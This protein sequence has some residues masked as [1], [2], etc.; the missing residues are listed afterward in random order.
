M[1]SC[2]DPTGIDFKKVNLESEDGKAFVADLTN[3]ANSD[4]NFFTSISSMESYIKFADSNKEKFEL[5]F[6]I[7]GK[8][9]GSDLTVNLKNIF[10]LTSKDGMTE[11][12]I[13][14]SINDKNHVINFNLAN[15]VDGKTGFEYS[16]GELTDNAEKEKL[17]DK[18]SNLISRTFYYVTDT[19]KSL[20]NDIFDK[21]VLTKLF[22]Y[23]SQ[24][25]T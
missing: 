8:D 15:A 22:S 21:E 3:S 7:I 23:F 6:K 5:A 11:A 25:T 9:G 12:N 4:S 20:F 16:D 24:E 2:G 13:T 1:I 18:I 10:K 14:V 19:T 17:I